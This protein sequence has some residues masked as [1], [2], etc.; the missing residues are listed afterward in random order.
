MYRKLSDPQRDVDDQI[1]HVRGLV[2]IRTLL[3]DRG[4]TPAELDRCDDVI[5]GCRRELAELVARAG[6]CASAA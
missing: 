4:A 6:V 5:A 3:A 2:L 1:L